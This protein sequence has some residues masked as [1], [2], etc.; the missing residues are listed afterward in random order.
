MTPFVSGTNASAFDQ[1]VLTLAWD[2]VDIAKNHVFVY[3]QQLLVRPHV[4]LFVWASHGSQGCLLSSAS[5]KKTFGLQRIDLG[6]PDGY[7]FLGRL[8]GAACLGC[9]MNPITFVHM[10][11]SMCLFLNLDSYVNKRMDICFGFHLARY[12][13]FSLNIFVFQIMI[14]NKNILHSC[15]IILAY[16]F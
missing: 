8:P 12:F 10:S 2:R 4:C 7:R 15:L 16:C 1:L 6:V 3:G 14:C 5:A 11:D 9:N 13:V